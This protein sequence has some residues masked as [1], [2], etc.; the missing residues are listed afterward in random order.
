MTPLTYIDIIGICGG[1]LVIV[2]LIPQLYRIIKNKSAND[3]SLIMY[4]LLF[5]AQILWT[6]YGVLKNDLQVTITNSIS[7]FITTL[8]IFS[9]IYYK[10]NSSLPV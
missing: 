5:C 7:G 6:S 9:S 2:C 4:V 3:V 1:I 10:R 8:I